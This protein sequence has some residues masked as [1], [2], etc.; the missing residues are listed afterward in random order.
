MLGAFISFIGFIL[1]ICWW[2]LAK[3]FRK[4][5]KGEESMP[6]ALF[7]I[8]C[9]LTFLVLGFVIMVVLSWLPDVLPRPN[10]YEMSFAIQILI[11]IAI[12]AIQCY[13]YVKVAKKSKQP[14][15]VEDVDLGIQ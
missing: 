3:Q 14:T 5:C 1:A 2:V 4:Y 11:M 6:V 10:N 9:I 7:V 13:K 12:I 8:Y 15:K